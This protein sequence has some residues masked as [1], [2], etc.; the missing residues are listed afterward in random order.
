MTWDIASETVTL[1]RYRAGFRP[2]LIFLEEIKP[3]LEIVEY[4][5]QVR[6]E[7]EQIFRRRGSSR[8]LSFCDVVVRRLLT[9]CRVLHLIEISVLW[10]LP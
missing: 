8:R 6:D 1:L 10:V 5:Q 4:G 7:A 3:N 2:A 9:I